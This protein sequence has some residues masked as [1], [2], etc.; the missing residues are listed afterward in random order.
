[1][2]E[3]F[4]LLYPPQKPPKF[5]DVII[6]TSIYGQPAGVKAAEKIS[7]KYHFIINAMQAFVCSDIHAILSRNVFVVTFLFKLWG[8]LS[9]VKQSKKFLSHTI[10]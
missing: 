1:M 2:T 9:G 4:P 8:L 5:D 6:Q 3:N 7:V 10:S